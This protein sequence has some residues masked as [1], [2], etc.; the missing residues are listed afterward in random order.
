MFWG[1]HRRDSYSYCTSPLSSSILMLAV[2]MHQ[3]SKC[4]EPP[5][6]Q[7]TNKPSLHPGHG[8]YYFGIVYKHTITHKGMLDLYTRP[9]YIYVS[10]T[11]HFCITFALP[12]GYSRDLIVRK[13]PYNLC[14]TFQWN[15]R[16]RSPL[17]SP[18]PTPWVSLLGVS[19]ALWPR[20]SCVSPTCD[21]L[22][23]GA[24]LKGTALTRQ[25][26]ARTELQVKTVM[27]GVSCFDLA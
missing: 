17:S 19:V 27:H 10:D 7:R 4:R 18:P 6:G 5:F 25:C 12:L 21:F 15:G 24:G 3:E 26:S 11:L 1:Y 16:E 20:W 23:G 2:E 8:A 22:L 13:E 9:I 14:G